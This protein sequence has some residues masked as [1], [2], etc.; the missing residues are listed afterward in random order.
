MNALLHVTEHL[1]ARAGATFVDSATLADRN[2]LI[3]HVDGESRRLPLFSSS[4]T[5]VDGSAVELMITN[6]TKIRKASSAPAGTWICSVEASLSFNGPAPALDFSREGFT[7]LSQ[8]VPAETVAWMHGTYKA[9]ASDGRVLDWG[10]KLS[11]GELASR[12]FVVDAGDGSQLVQMACGIVFASTSASRFLVDTHAVRPFDACTYMG[13]DDGAAA[14]SFSLFNDLFSVLAAEATMDSLSGT[15]HHHLWNHFRLNGG[16]ELHIAVPPPGTMSYVYRRNTKECISEI[17]LGL[18]DSGWI[19]H[20]VAMQDK[21]SAMGVVN[22]VLH[23]NGAMQTGAIVEHS[24]LAGQ[25]IIGAGSFVSGLTLDAGS[26]LTI[27]PA[28]IL[29]CV[30]LN[31]LNSS[32]S[33]AGAATGSGDIVYVLCG[34]SDEFAVEFVPGEAAGGT[35]SIATFGNK[36]WSKG[37]FSVPG[38]E[39]RDVWPDGTRRNLFNAKLFVS[40][41]A[42]ERAG[43]SPL[44]F[45]ILPSTD[46]PVAGELERW[47]FAERLSISDITRNTD[48]EA[49]YCNREQIATAI[50]GSTARSVLL[51]REDGDL[52]HFYQW[53]ARHEQWGALPILDAVAAEA[54]GEDIAARAMAHIADLLACFAGQEGGLRSG[55]AQ[56]KAWQPALDKLRK[57]QRREAVDMMARVRADW[58]DSPAN[59]IRA[60]RH[61]EGAGAILV[62]QAVESCRDFIAQTATEPC[63]I[64][65]MVVAESAARID[66]AGGWTDTPPITFECGGVV[67]NAAVLV[68][69]ERPIGASVRCKVEF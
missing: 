55:P 65:Q 44:P 7:A 41:L 52:L 61:Y 20:S 50:G 36:P 49:M 66:L 26:E 38:I 30:P 22:S 34:T 14:L 13:Q 56:N 25:W 1:S 68:D 39:P 40:V 46:P 63:P 3:L 64:G 11:I 32:A 5:S 62:R 19:D 23:G 57:G 9:R 33:G 31:A 58:I 59:L 48:M 21:S 54:K 35:P 18:N 8:R 45:W 27:P 53:C 42:A 60:A 12:G 10:H 16:L 2:V 29:Q 47:R 43:C 51:A 24:R 6:I 37:I 17:A 67:A 69:G 28:T 15:T 4:A